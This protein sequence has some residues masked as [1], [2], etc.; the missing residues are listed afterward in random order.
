MTSMVGQHVSRS[1]TNILTHLGQWDYNEFVLQDWCN[2]GNC[3]RSH[4]K[5]QSHVGGM[6][7]RVVNL[8]ETEYALAMSTYSNHFYKGIGLQT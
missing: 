1:M 4:G 7:N 6:S 8:T 2:G 3:L 5:L